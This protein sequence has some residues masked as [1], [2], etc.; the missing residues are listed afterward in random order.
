MRQQA[1]ANL[2]NTLLAFGP[3]GAVTGLALG[4][5]GGIVRRSAPAAA[6]A[7]GLGLVVG[8]LLAAGASLG[9]LPLR[10]RMLQ[11]ADESDLLVALATHG[12][13]WAAV[14]AGG[15][16]ALGLGLGGRGR[17]GAA[18]LGGLLGAVA[19]TVLYEFLGGL[20]FPLAA[21]H[22][23]LAATPVTRLLARLLVTT[24]AA[25]GAAWSVQSAE[26]TPP[27]AV[28]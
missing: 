18:V 9:M 13:I 27:A 26:R 7:A 21:T 4:L 5:A 10:T 25:A 19:G 16:L 1:R 14:G 15:G 8:G 3:L 2:L 28:S 23:L 24:F 6:V 11:T 22:R 17:V 20:A 12:A